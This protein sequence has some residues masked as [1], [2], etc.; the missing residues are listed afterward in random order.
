MIKAISTILGFIIMIFVSSVQSHAQNS[1]IS[2][3]DIADGPDQIMVGTMQC[4]GKDIQ[5]AKGLRWTPTDYS[6]VVTINGKKNIRLKPGCYTG[7]KCGLVD[8]AESI[9]IMRYLACGGT[10]LPDDYVIINVK[11]LKMGTIDYIR[12]KSLGFNK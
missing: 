4:F 10:A 2:L 11:T 1:I 7:M 12:G 9:I 8:G 6:P 3:D 5:Y